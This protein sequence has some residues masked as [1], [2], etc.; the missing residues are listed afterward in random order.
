MVEPNWNERR[1]SDR[2]RGVQH[3]S[4]IAPLVL[5]KIGVARPQPVRVSHT[6]VK[7]AFLPGLP[8]VPS[9]SLGRR[10]HGIDTD[11]K[12]SPGATTR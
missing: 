9:R 2:G 12:Q 11:A 5:A 3:I 4:E 1:D 10:Y 6:K 8:A 7:K